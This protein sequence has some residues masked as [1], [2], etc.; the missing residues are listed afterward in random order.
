MNSSSPR[1]RQPELV[2]Q[3]LLD[4][5]AEI[6]VGQGLHAVTVQSVAAAAGVTKG[7]LFHHFASKDDLIHEV[8]RQQLEQVDAIVEEALAQDGAS[9]GCF[10]RAYVLAIF[11]VCDTAAPV[12]IALF[13]EPSHRRI[14]TDWVNQRLERHRETDGSVA[15]TAVR[16][17]A[18]GVWLWDLWDEDTCWIE[19][20]AALRDHLLAA[21][22]T[23]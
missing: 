7:G 5:T 10:T 6:A 23:E 4:A 15:L 3:R 12:S 13:A 8:V 14:W 20:R 11:A 9:Y 16:M 2:R 17:A 21:T 18:D 22:R 19:D 1:K